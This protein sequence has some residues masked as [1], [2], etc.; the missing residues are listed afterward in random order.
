M[1]SFW[2]ILTA[3]CAFAL[4]GAA[5]AACSG[6]GMGSNPTASM[7]SSSGSQAVD[8]LGADPP[9]NDVDPDNGNS[10]LKRLN[11]TT[12]IGSTVD[13][14][15]GDLNPYGLDV[16]PIDA[17]LLKAGDLVV[18]NFNKSANVK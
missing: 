11:M 9:Q 15:N 6:G 2:K 17:G 18:C 10:V 16:A 12:T 4:L 3:T 1:P 5:L 8:T 7:P 14:I 13:P